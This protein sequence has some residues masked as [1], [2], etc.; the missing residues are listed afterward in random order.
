MHAA[1]AKLEEIR[2]RVALVVVK[3]VG[4]PKGTRA[5]LNDDH[6][7]EAKLGR[8]IPVL[9][10][11]TVVTRDHAGRQALPASTDRA[12]R[13]DHDRHGRRGRRSSE[14]RHPGA[15]L[16]HKPTNKLEV[17]A[18]I[19]G[20]TFN[21]PGNATRGAGPGVRAAYEILPVGVLDT[22]D[23]FAIGAG[24]DWIATS[25]DAH[26]WVPITVQW[27]LWLTP[28]LSLRIE[29]GAALMFGAGTHVW[30]ALYAGLRYRVWKKLYVTGPGRNSR[31]RRSERAGFCE[32]CENGA[33]LAPLLFLSG[34]V[35]SG[36]ATFVV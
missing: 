24:A 9:P 21:P 7:D 28:E 8:P 36:L 32:A 22:T 33:I 34:V 30:P 19:V 13:H 26:I 31:T 4:A 6:L 15:T 3:I 25:T 23:T 18:A 17:E 11:D 10:G 27:N 35:A 1:Y 16:G 14:A 20:E 2:P 29:P 12:G 5:T